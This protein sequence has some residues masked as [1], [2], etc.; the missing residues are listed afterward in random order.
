MV[1]KRSEGYW[2]ASGFGRKIKK[3]KEMGWPHDPEAKGIALARYVMQL[4]D[5]RCYICGN[6]CKS[7]SEPGSGVYTRKNCSMTVDHVRPEVGHFVHNLALC[8]FGCNQKKWSLYDFPRVLYGL[9]VAKKSQ[10]EIHL[11]VCRFLK[12]SP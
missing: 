9:D 7:N 4:T 8:C 5:N 10:P 3:A 1:K 11:A 6:V 2:L 12:I